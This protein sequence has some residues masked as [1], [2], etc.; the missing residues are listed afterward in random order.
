MPSIRLV[1]GD[2]KIMWA[3][4]D[5]LQESLLKIEQ[6]IADILETG[7]VNS[8]TMIHAAIDVKANT[9]SCIKVSRS[10]TK[11]SAAVAA[12]TVGL[13]V[14]LQAIRVAGSG[15]PNWADSVQY[16]SDTS[17][18]GLPAHVHASSNDLPCSSLTHITMN[19]TRSAGGGSTLPNIQRARNNDLV[20]TGSIGSSSVYTGSESDRDNNSQP[21]VM[22]RSTKSK[23]QLNKRKKSSPTDNNNTDD[24]PQ[25]VPKFSDVLSKDIQNDSNRPTRK[26]RGPPLSKVTRTTA[27]S[28]VGTEECY[29]RKAAVHVDVNKSVYCISICSYRI[30]DRGHYFTL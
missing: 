6:S 2:L 29:K 8:N 15:R 28:L 26:E 14:G 3:K 30:H 9:A 27:S 17:L 21:L 13:P 7:K 16:A 18:A 11:L 24:N 22:I 10:V 25:K 12:L 4:L 19:N 23:R 20:T 1:E 5:K